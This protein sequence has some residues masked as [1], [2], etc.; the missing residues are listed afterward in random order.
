[1]SH[2]TRRDEPTY[3]VTLTIRATIPVSFVRYGQ[4]DGPIDG[5]D[6]IITPTDA[7]ENALWSGVNKGSY[8]DHEGSEQ[9]VE[10]LLESLGFDVALPIDGEAVLEDAE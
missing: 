2:P 8:G 7:I 5:D 1:M 3:L 6:D 10:G 9:T 4:G